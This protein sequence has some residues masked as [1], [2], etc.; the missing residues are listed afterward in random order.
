MNSTQLLDALEEMLDY[1]LDT[2]K[3]KDYIQQLRVKLFNQ[4]LQ[5]ISSKEYATGLEIETPQGKVILN[6]Y[7]LNDMTLTQREIPAG[8]IS[9]MEVLDIE[10]KLRA[11]N[12]Q[13]KED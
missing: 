13:I 5:K 11:H 12:V 9:N 3:A 1:D 4:Q 10:I 8:S 6:D 2:E 7:I